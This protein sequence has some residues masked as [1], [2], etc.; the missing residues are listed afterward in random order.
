MNQRITGG[1]KVKQEKVELARHLRQEM[2]PA[3]MKLWSLIRRRQINGC[4]FRRQQIIAGFIVDFYCP[5]LALVIEIDG[6]VHVG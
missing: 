2:T 4:R 5:E 6:D 3:E 1:Q